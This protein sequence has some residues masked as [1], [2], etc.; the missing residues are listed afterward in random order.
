[1]TPELAQSIISEIYDGKTIESLLKKYDTNAKA[2]YVFIDKVPLLSQEYARA[3]IAKA[4]MVVD[5]IIDI[6]DNDEDA[7]RARVRTDARKWYASKMQPKKYGD[8]IDLNITESVDIAGAL[9]DAKARVLS[10]RDQRNIMDAELVNTKQIANAK[11]TGST[12]VSEQIPT[13]SKDADEKELLELL[14]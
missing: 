1:M 11:P 8:R 12:P 10:V 6:A 4:E 7:N 5:Q 13:N 14:K 2:F 3:Q 9:S